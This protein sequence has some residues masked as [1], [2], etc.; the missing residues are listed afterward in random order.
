MD[1]DDWLDGWV[2]GM[3]SWMIDELDVCLM[4]WLVDWSIGRLD[5]CLM[6]W[7]DGWILAFWILFNM[8]IYSTSNKYYYTAGIWRIVIILTIEVTRTLVPCF[9][10]LTPLLLSPIARTD[11]TAGN[12]PVTIHKIVPKYFPKFPNLFFAPI[13]ASLRESYNS[14]ARVC[15]QFMVYGCVWLC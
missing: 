9:S 14:T 3:I 5:E 4:S 1:D 11:F 7:V 13:C 15:S 6:D 10:R 8:G 12:P 2:A